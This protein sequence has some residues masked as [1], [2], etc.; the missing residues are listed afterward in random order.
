M[1]VH[2]I[3]LRKSA[4]C[5]KVSCLPICHSTWM[6]I[7]MKAAE[8]K[9]VKNGFPLSPF[10]PPCSI[11]VTPRVGRFSCLRGNSFCPS[12]PLPPTSFL[13]CIIFN[14]EPI[15]ATGC[16]IRWAS[17]QKYCLSFSNRF[18]LSPKRDGPRVGFTQPMAHH[19]SY[20]DGIYSTSN[21]MWVSHNPARLKFAS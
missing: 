21:L 3:M 13:N 19:F 14:E 1:K 7:A 15:L 16:S 10:L 9:S 4:D 12:L 18:A 5:F 2:H 17:I 8:T 6:C 11:I 20:H